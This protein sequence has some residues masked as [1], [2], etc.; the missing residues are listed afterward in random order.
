M[1]PIFTPGVSC[2]YPKS[3]GKNWTS[4]KAIFLKLV[5]VIDQNHLVFLKVYPKVKQI[6]DGSGIYC[7]GE[8]K[9]RFVDIFQFLPQ[10]TIALLESKILI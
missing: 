6:T 1:C 3:W 5:K 10:V 4:L 9:E 7:D 8:I 2:F